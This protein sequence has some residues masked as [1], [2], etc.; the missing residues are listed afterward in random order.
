MIQKNL[1]L[2][3]VIKQGKTT[4]RFA[5]QDKKGLYLIATL[6]NNNLV[7]HSKIVSFKKF[8]ILLNTY[9]QKGKLNYPKVFDLQ[10]GSEKATLE[11]SNEIKPIIPTLQDS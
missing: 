6:L 5:I 3:K 11:S 10:E 1:G 4:S 8:L 2:G 9:N 7:T